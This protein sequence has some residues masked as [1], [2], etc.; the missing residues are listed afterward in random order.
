MRARAALLLA[1]F[2]LFSFTSPLLA[3]ITHPYTVDEKAQVNFGDATSVSGHFGLENY[4]HDYVGGYLHLTFTYSH[5]NCCFASYPPALYIT[6]LDPRASATPGERTTDVIY[7]IL[8]GAATDW[9]LYDVQFDT[10]GY[11]KIVKQG[12]ITEIVN[13]HVSVTGQTDTDY[14]A[15]ANTFALA[16]P[17]AFSMSFTPLLIHEASTGSSVSEP[18]A[19]VVPLSVNDRPRCVETTQGWYCPSEQA[20]Q[21]YIMILLEQIIALLKKAVEIVG[22]QAAAVFSIFPYNK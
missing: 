13:S 8:A 22:Q 20:R 18:A 1:L 14:A 16:P 11:T 3:E 7:N 9:Y 4:T 10:T 5:S 6:S 17:T 19:V 15:L 12:G 21:N 2:G